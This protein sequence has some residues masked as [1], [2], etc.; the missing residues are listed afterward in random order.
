MP[1]ETI[2]YWRP[3]DLPGLEVMTVHHS[4]RIWRTMHDQYVFCA[5]LAG[6]GLWRY[7]GVVHAS[8]PG[9]TRLLEPGEVHRD[10]ELCGPTSHVALF[11]AP[12]LVTTLAEALGLAPGPYAATT[13][14][15]ACFAALRRW[16][17]PLAPTDDVA[18]TL[19]A[20]L[21]TVLLRT[22][23]DRSVPDPGARQRASTAVRRARALLH[24]RFDEPLALAEVAGASGLTKPHLVRA[25]HAEVGLPPIEYL[26]HLR[27]ARAREGLR[28]GHSPAAAAL[29]CGFCDQSHLTRWF[30]KVVGVTPGQYAQ[31]HPSRTGPARGVLRP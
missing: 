15:P 1:T 29:A 31:P 11:I 22:A 26:M 6:G 9:S 24:D 16:A 14:D 12:A 21:R 25:F 13:D 3:Q 19:H 4:T 23:A 5:V 2:H 7:R 27:V 17:D 8:G 28:A 20:S 10:L 30:K 18:A